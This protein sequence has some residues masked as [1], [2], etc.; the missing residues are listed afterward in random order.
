MAADFRSDTVTVPTRAMRQAMA[1]A[2][3]GDDVYGE[4]PTVNRLEAEAAALLGKEAAL[5]VPTATMANQLAVLTHTERGDEM[6]CDEDAHIYYYEAGAPA[7]WAGVM[8]RTL[9]HR[10]GLLEVETLVEA[11]RPA[12]IHHPRPRLL[13]LENTHNRAGGAAVPARHLAALADAA[14]GRGLVVNLDGSRLF[15]AAVALDEPVAVLAAPADSVTVCL[16]KGLGAPLGSLLVGT[17]PF[18][19]RARRYR[20][21][22]GGGMRQAG[23]VAAAGLYAL[24]HHVGALVE[25]HRRAGA[26]AAGLRTVPGLRVSMPEDPLRPTNMVMVDCPGPAAAVVEAALAHDIRLGQMGERRIR[27]VTHRDVGDADVDRLVS[28]FQEEGPR[29]WG[30]TGAAGS[31]AR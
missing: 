19:E 9:P 6:F 11:V 10:G 14:H 29:L 31:A 21:Q 28:F 24:Q 16:S 17:R 8:C 30:P 26:I 2:E 13:S 22:L 27:V 23:V 15:N 1:E 20:K 25:D 18:V 7:L 12:N 3:V 5:Y 4:D